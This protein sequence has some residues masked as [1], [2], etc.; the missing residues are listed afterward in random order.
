MPR[1]KER[2]PRNQW[3]EE[4]SQERTKPWIALGIA[5]STFFKRKKLARE[6]AKS[7]DN[8]KQAE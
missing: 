7:S 2:T 6:V 3:L 4:H 5:R 1:K 8:S